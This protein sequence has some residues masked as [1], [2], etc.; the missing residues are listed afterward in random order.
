MQSFKSDDYQSL[1]MLKVCLITLQTWS[2][3][4]D[5][6]SRQRNLSSLV[7]LGYI[8]IKLVLLFRRKFSSDDLF[9]FKVQ[10]ASKETH[11]QFRCLVSRRCIRKQKLFLTSQFVPIN[12]FHKTLQITANSRKKLGVNPIWSTYTAFVLLFLIVL[13]VFLFYPIKVCIHK[14]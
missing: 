13:I 7:P 12:N 2:N 5:N 6:I 9:A 11:V 3:L 10:I 14:I 1:E 8:H 4:V